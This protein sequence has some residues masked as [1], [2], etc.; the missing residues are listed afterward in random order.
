MIDMRRDKDTNIQN[1]IKESSSKYLQEAIDQ[2]QRHG[3]AVSYFE[4]GMDAAEYL[5]DQIQGKTVGFGDSATLAA[6]HLAEKLGEKNRVIDPGPYSG[7]DFYRIA[8]EAMDTDVFLLSVNAASASGELVNIDSSGN[9]VGG[10]LFGHEKV[11]FVFTAEKIE[12]SLEEAV[13]RAKNIAAPRNAKRFGFRTPC[14][15]EGDRCYDCSSPDR[16]CNVLAIY[17]RKEKHMEE[18]IVI[19]GENV[20]HNG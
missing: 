5:C 15:V 4:K 11:Y 16:I 14:A 9:R 12:P 17:M 10:S 19:I 7:E 6:L 8:R 13:W 20:T 1:A 3:F 2:F 18:E